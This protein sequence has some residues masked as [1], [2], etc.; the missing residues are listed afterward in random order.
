MVDIRFSCTGCGQTLEAPAEMAGD[1]VA[2]PSCSAEIRVP[3]GSETA[4]Q[5]TTDAGGD[6]CPECGAGLDADAVLCVQCGYHLTLGKKIS[7]DFS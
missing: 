7:T 2:C 3:A 5:P 1:L 6:T 4:Q